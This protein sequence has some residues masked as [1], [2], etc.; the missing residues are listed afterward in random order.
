M[1][2]AQGFFGGFGDQGMG[3]NGVAAGM[4]MGD[5]SLDGGY[6]GWQCQQAMDMNGN[7]GANS[8]YYAGNGYNQQN[9]QDHSF[10]RMPYHPDSQSN[11]FQT[12]N[13]FHGHGRAF[14][15][16]NSGRGLPHKVRGHVNQR[17]YYQNRNYG[18]GNRSAFPHI[19]SSREEEYGAFFHQL[20]PDLQNG[21]S[22]NQVDE[23]AVTNCNQP[24]SSVI[25]R[26]NGEAHA[27]GVN[28]NYRQENQDHKLNGD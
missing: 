27:E 3:M 5:M 13:H 8:G 17:G 16:N 19:T 1:A 28:E 6:G 7:F 24:S 11:S 4:N 9:F 12:K 15:T 18:T 2:M 14:L 21:Q 22:K 23:R 26:N 25:D 20:P 10:Q